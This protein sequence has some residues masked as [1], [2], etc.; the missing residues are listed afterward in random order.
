[1]DVDEATLTP[2]IAREAA[3]AV[4]DSR[5]FFPTGDC[6]LLV[7]GVLFKLHKFAL[8]RDAESDSAFS[9]M[10][11]DAEGSPTEIIPLDDS[12]E[13]FRHFCWALYALPD[14]IYRLGMAQK[15]QKSTGGFGGFFNKS[16][17]LEKID[18]RKFL[19]ICNLAHKYL[20]PR[21]ELWAW[22]VLQ[23]HLSSYFPSCTLDDLEYLVDLGMR[24]RKAHSKFLLHDSE[25]EWL[26]RLR[27][28]NTAYFGRA[29]TLAEKH[30]RTSFQT[31]IYMEMRNQLLVGPSAKSLDEFLTPMG[32]VEH[33]RECFIHGHAELS[34]MFQAPPPKLFVT[35]VPSYSP[36]CATHANCERAWSRIICLD[37]RNLI[38]ILE[39]ARQHGR[40][41][42][43]PAPC[44]GRFLDVDS[45]P[46]LD[47]VKTVFKSRKA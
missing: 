15:T 42:L 40:T 9:H 16:T 38:P 25:K 10:F 34:A 21:F 37:F 3:A 44:V 28:K 22:S 14:E 8:C 12:V 20:M 43:A 6:T 33:Q 32:L 5:Y 18:M 30:N 2:E 36:P 27:S 31:D 47:V 17:P 26:G 35:T 19:G 29:L 45:Y 39:I 46:R 41:S 11:Q 24:F 23:P 7:G 1:M 4:P 13:E